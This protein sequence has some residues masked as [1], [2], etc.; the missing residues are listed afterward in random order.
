MAAGPADCG[1]DG[2]VSF[3]DRKGR[4]GKDGFLTPFERRLSQTHDRFAP[5]GIAAINAGGMTLH[6]FFQ[7]PFTPFVPDTVINGNGSRLRLGK[8][9]I[10]II[11]SMDLLVIDEVSMIRA[12]LLDAVDAVLRR[13]RIMPDLLVECNCC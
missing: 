4:Y 5:T 1:R 11:R 12:D 13:Y 9:K 8:E 6:S 2:H 7:L 10:R 3:L